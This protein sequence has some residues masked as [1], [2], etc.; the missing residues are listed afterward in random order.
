MPIAAKPY[1][2]LALHIGTPPK[3]LIVSKCIRK[4]QRIFIDNKNERMRYYARKSATEKESKDDENEKNIIY[5]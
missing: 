4:E 3:N 5:I 1:P 2:T